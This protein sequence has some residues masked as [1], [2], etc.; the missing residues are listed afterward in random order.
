MTRIF[1][2]LTLVVLS[3]SGCVSSQHGQKLPSEAYD[4]V[5]YVERQPKD[6]R[7]LAS[8]ISNILNERGFNAT[9]G[10]RGSVPEDATHIVSYVDNWYWDMRMYLLNLKIEVRDRKSNYIIAYG[11]S[12]QTSLAAMGKTHDDIINLALDEMISRGRVD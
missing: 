1:L 10:E 11:E 2:A 12:H 7:N 3:L 9:H 4:K 5:F 6:E 8:N